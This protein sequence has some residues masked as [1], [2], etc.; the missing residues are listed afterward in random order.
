MADA[1]KL[2][3]YEIYLRVP[4]LLALQKPRA[5]RTHEDELL[6]QIVHQIEE[7]WMATAVDALERAVADMDAD[8]LVSA[9]GRFRRVAEIQRLSIAQLRLIDTMTPHA[10]LAI[11]KGLGHGSGQESPGFNALLQIAPKLEAALDRVLARHG[12]TALEVHRNPQAS[13]LLIQL[14]EAIL[15]FDQLFQAFRYAHLV[16]VKRIIGAGTPSL[17]GKPTELLERSMRSAFFPKLWEVRETMFADFVAG[18][19][20]GYTKG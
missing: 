19:G 12:T 1:K 8:G 2:T 7:L 15:D 20:L 11:R 18:T 16:I 14:T 9:I 5:E 13:P 4:E 17:K 3:D 6:F 10:Y